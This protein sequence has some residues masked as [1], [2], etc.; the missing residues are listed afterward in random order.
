MG[1]DVC[2]EGPRLPPAAMKV[3]AHLAH[4]ARPAG[5]W[6]GI[7]VAFRVAALAPNYG[8]IVAQSCPPGMRATCARVRLIAA[9]AHCAAVAGVLIQPNR[10]ALSL[11][12]I[13]TADERG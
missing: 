4:S 5:R 1:R 11:I 10:S 7:C 2:C 12:L 6:I 3:H 13:A 8:W 9:P